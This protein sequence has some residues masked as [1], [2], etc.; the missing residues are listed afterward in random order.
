MGMRTAPS[1]RHCAFSQGSRTSTTR[2]FSPLSRRCFSSAA[3]ISR[4]F[5]A[6]QAP[7]SEGGRYTKTNSRLKYC[8]GL[9]DGAFW[10]DPLFFN[11]LVF[12]DES[13]VFGWG[14]RCL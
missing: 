10:R 11:G 12:A 7:A 4:S 5:M 3:L 8:T 6:L 2:S 1:I 13:Q 9:L 14:G